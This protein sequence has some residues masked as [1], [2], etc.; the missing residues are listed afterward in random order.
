MNRRSFLRTSAAAPLLAAPLATAAGIPSEE[1]Q[2]PVFN[3]HKSVRN[4]VKIASIDLLRSGK[5][6]FQPSGPYKVLDGPQV[7]IGPYL[8]IRFGH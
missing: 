3:L 2:K 6:F 1:W 8:G 5:Q 4:P 7:F